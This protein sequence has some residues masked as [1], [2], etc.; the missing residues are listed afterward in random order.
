MSLVKKESA[1]KWINSFIILC[2][3]L[4]AYVVIQFAYQMGEWFD[5]EAKVKNFIMISQAIGLVV[6]IA[7][8]LVVIKNTKMMTLMN[9]VYGELLKV[10][11]PKQDDVLKLTVGIV[12][13]VSIISLMFLGVDTFIR[14]I[15]TFLY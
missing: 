10:I 2:C 5:F 12:I 13:G 14:W 3:A 7:A 4:V 1:G 8:F 15:L 11:W 9:D 6:G